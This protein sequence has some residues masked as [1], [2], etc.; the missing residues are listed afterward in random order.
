MQDY[1]NLQNLQDYQNLQPDPV[2]SGALIVFYAVIIVLYVVA[3][4]KVYTKAGKPGWAALVPIYNIYVLLQIIG[5]PG[6]WLLLYLIPFVN[7]IISLITAMDLAKVFGKSGLFGVFLLWLFSF[8]GYP[9][10]AFG[11]TTYTGGSKT[12]TTSTTVPAALP[13]TP[14]TPVTPPAT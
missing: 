4:W 2:M 11:K 5:R 9:I 13:A 12:S 1:Q 14:P 10:L 3:M 8:I 6:W 7:I